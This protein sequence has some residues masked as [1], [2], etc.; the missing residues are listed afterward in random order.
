VLDVRNHTNDPAGI[1]D[2]LPP[3]DVTNVMDQTNVKLIVIL[4]G[5]WGDKL[6]R[7]RHHG[8]HRPPEN[9]RSV[10]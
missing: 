8:H 4:T 10:S 5:M 7:H 1:G 9:A 2:R 3:W 6:Q